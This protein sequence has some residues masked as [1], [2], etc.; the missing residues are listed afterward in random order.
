MRSDVSRGGLEGRPWDRDAPRAVVDWESCWVELGEGEVL[1]SNMDLDL[2][3]L[4][5]RLLLLLLGED[6]TRL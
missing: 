5:G 1:I 4:G 3:L 6:T 2:I